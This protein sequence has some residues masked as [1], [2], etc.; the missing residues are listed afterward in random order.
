ML[1]GPIFRRE[2][3]AAAS[4]RDLFIVRVVL[5]LLLGG[6]AALAGLGLFDREA[7]DRGLYKAAE[8]Q[9]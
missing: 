5:A 9:I 3:K 6:M 4:R 7:R 8:L 1:P 2:L